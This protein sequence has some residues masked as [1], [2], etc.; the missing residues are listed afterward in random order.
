MDCVQMTRQHLAFKNTSDFQV[1]PT[2]SGKPQADENLLSRQCCVTVNKCNHIYVK[3]TGQK[4]THYLPYLVCKTLILFPV[5]LAYFWP[6]LNYNCSKNN[7]SYFIMLAHDI[8]G[9]WWWYGSRSRTLSPSFH[10]VLLPCDRW[11]Q[12]GRL[13]K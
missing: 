12:R 9:R 4:N 6:L 13:T 1:F 7:A 11:Q 5:L 3:D 8:R 10:Y 2:F